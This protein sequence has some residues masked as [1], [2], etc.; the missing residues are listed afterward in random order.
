MHP[1][2]NEGSKPPVAS[3]RPILVW[4]LPTR[5][6]HWLL[7]ALVITSFVTGK[8]G[9]LWMQ[10]HMWSGYAILEL[11]GFRLAWGVVGGRHARFSA[12]LRGPGAVLR[13]VLTMHRRDTP[14]PLG[15]NP[16]GGWSVM[17]ML[18]TLLIQALT[19]LF[20]NDDIFIEGPL[21]SWVN[22]AASDW[23]THVHRLN[24]KI[25]LLLVAVRRSGG[26]LFAQHFE[27]HADGC[28]FLL[29]GF[30]A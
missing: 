27:C 17:A 13:Y 3:G 26:G 24:Q 8:I 7:A 20:A 15:H 21:F 28:V 4:D 23:L 14:E 1:D 22:K 29:L 16:L 11:I 30:P 9:G 6:F 2:T 19:G 18:I 12:F 5:L 10:Y 25:I